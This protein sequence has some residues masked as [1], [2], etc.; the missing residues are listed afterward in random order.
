MSNNWPIVQFG[1]FTELVKRPT[2]ASGVVGSVGVKLYG[3]GVHV[4]EEKSIFE[5]R[6]ARF[7]IRKDDLIYNDMWARK[8]S[9]AIVPDKYDGYVASAHFPTWELDNTRVDPAFLGW[10][11]RTPEFWNMCE[12]S[13]QGTTGRNAISKRGF[14]KLEIPLPPPGEQRRV[15]ARIEEL[16]AKVERA[17]ILRGQ[18][19]GAV[20]SLVTSL[21]F[22]LAGE[23]AFTV[24]KFLA[25]DEQREKIEVG[26]EY[27]QIGIKGFGQGLFPKEAVNATQTTYK[28]FNRLYEG[29]IVLSQPKG[30]EGAIAVCPQSLAGYYASP[31][32]R[33]FRCV[34]GQAIPE[35]LAEILATPWFWK[36]LKD[37][38][39]GLGGRRQ[40]TRP[41]QFLSMEIPMPTVE[42]QRQAVQIFRKLCPI[43]RHQAATAAKLDALLP[44]IL[45]KAFKGEL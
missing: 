15:V 11:F 36:Q 41:E 44:S 8:G 31:E 30:W 20:D 10:Y 38:Q 13:S 14:R 17:Q 5:F 25:L 40:R 37:V 32:Y 3:E 19:V 39:R 33:T 22:K 29:A 9:V 6:A 18:A 42:Q 34:E 1:E 24:D 43:K 16:A 23:K 7:D 12:N 28:W 27:P 2:E 4:V 45:D 35:Y 26:K 21:H